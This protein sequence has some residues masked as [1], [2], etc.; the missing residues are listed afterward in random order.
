MSRSRRP[1]RLEKCCC[2]RHEIPILGYGKNRQHF[3]CTVLHYVEE[4]NE[5]FRKFKELKRLPLTEED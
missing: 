1:R 4:R 2:G 3:A 5:Q